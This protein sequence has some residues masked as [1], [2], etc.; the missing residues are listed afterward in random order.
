MDLFHVIEEG[1]AIVR[2]RG[3]F[4]QVKIYR[5]ADDVFAGYGGGFIKL[6]GMKSTTSPN[7]SWVDIDG[8]NITLDRG[9]PKWNAK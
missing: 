2:S 9:Q 7:I 3:V 8:P 6:L 4:R 5:R 1:Q